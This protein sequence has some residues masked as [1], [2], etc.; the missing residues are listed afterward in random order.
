[1]IKTTCLLLVAAL[2]PLVTA[3]HHAGDEG[4]SKTAAD[5]SKPAFGAPE[6]WWVETADTFNPSDVGVTGQATLNTARG[7]H[8][9]AVGTDDLGNPYLYAAGGSTGTA[10]LASVEVA[11]IGLFGDLGGACT[12]GACKFRLLGRT[13]LPSARTGLQL[14]PRTI[15]GDTTSLYALGGKTG[16]GGGAAVVTDVVRAIVLR[17]SGVVRNHSR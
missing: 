4:D 13:P 12:G 2:F 11:P 14:V 9:T 15:A 5:E 6:G 10:P 16:T 8:A 1:M 7:D 17:N 3:C